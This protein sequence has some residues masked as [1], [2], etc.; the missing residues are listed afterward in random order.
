MKLS[1]SPLK[2]IVVYY[3][4]VCRTTILKLFANDAEIVRLCIA[5]AQYYQA[6]CTVKVTPLMEKK[7]QPQFSFVIY[8]IYQISSVL[9]GK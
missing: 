8:F 7:G 1:F 2:N 4:Y 9:N 6:A 3:W 5:E